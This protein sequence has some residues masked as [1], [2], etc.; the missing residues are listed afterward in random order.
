MQETE[1]ITVLSNEGAQCSEARFMVRKDTFDKGIIG[2][3]WHGLFYTK[4]PMFA[5]KPGDITVD[6]GAHI[7]AFAVLAARKGAIVHAFEPEDDNFSLL[8]EQKVLNPD[9][10][11]FLIAEKLAVTGDGRSVKLIMCSDPANTGGNWTERQ[12]GNPD[13]AQSVVEVPSTTLSKI[14]E[15]LDRVDFLKMDCEGAE[16]EI[17][18]QAGQDAIAKVSK[19]AMEWHGGRE[20]FDVL[21]GFLNL[22][23]FKNEQF[24]GD[25]NMGSAFFWR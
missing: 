5:I 3:A 15:T 19:I 6:I 1:V 9:I 23:G 4:H 2:E 12:E 13:G 20:Q 8:M 25:E 10:S 18:M 17:L 7:G 11:K 14:V 16:Y 24:D 22:A 21:R